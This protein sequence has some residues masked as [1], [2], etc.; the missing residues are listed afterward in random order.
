M[1]FFFLRK[2]PNGKRRFIGTNTL[3]VIIAYLIYYRSHDLKD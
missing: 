3:E 2:L 1:D